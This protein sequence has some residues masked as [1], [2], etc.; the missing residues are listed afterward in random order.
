MKKA[1]DLRAKLVAGQD[2]AKA[3]ESLSEDPSAKGN[4]GDL[5]WFQPGQMDKPFSSRR[6]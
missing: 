5:G 2:F 6:P 1:A 4:K 3:A